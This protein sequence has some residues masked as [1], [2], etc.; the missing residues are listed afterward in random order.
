MLSD[1]IDEALMLTESALRFGA[2]NIEV[3]RGSSSDEFR[4]YSSTA[5]LLDYSY[6]GDQVS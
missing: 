3:V 2:N 6:T 5:Q 4:F 1:Q